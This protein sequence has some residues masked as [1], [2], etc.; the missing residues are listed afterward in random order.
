MVIFKVMDHTKIV[1]YVFFYSVFLT[2]GFMAWLLIAPFATALVTAAILVT[3]FYPAHE[4]IL[5]N[6]ARGRETLAAIISSSLLMSFVVVPILFIVTKIV[7]EFLAIY[8]NIQSSAAADFFIFTYIDTLAKSFGLELSFDFSEQ[9][10]LALEWITANASAIFSNTL[11]F[12][13]SV[14][15]VI[16]A[17]FYFFK[18]GKRLVDYLIHLSPLPDKDDILLLNRMA[19]SIR[20]TIRGT[21]FVSFI[22]GVVATTGFLIF[23]IPQAFVWG[24]L[25]ALGALIPGVGMAGIMVP[26]VAYLFF[27]GTTGATVGLAIWAVVAIVIVDNILAPQLMSRGNNLHPFIVLLSVLGGISLFGPIGFIVGPVIVTILFVLIQMFTLYNSPETR[28]NTR[29]K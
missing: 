5:R 8:Q 24:S 28:L 12:I 23:G 22:Q 2:A 15:V 21:L 29:K 26:A 3:I 20:S 16:F 19:L 1:E 11:S 9:F 18:D 13:L 14:L 7:R 27:V 6:I 10:I 4:I 25:G 17:V